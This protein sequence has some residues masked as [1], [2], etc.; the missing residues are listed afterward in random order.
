[1]EITFLNVNNILFFSCTL[2]TTLNKITLH[3]C[4]ICI[5]KN[6]LEN[7]FSHDHPAGDSAVEFCVW[8]VVLF[9]KAPLSLEGNRFKV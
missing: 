5:I 4:F 8:N 7:L 1:M 2:V 6:F 3:L 9:F